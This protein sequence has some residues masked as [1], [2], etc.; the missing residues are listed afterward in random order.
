MVE[1]RNRKWIPQ[2]AAARPTAIEAAQDEL[3][4]RL[5]NR[6]NTVVQ[7]TAIEAAHADALDF[8]TPTSFGRS[9][10]TMH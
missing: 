8:G 7:P 3:R 2:N 5:L 10:V 4:N 1:L 9:S 6:Q